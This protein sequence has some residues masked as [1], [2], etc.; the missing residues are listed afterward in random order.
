MSCRLAT[1]LNAANTVIAAYT[2]DNNGNLKTQTQK[3]DAVTT[4]DAITSFDYDPLNRLTKIT[5]ALAGITQYGYDGVDHLVSVTDPKTLITRYGVDGLDNQKQ[6]VS[7]DTGTTNSTYDAAGN[8]KTRTDARA[9][10]STYSYDALNRLT[11]VT[12][13]DTTPAIAYF[14]DDIASGNAGK[15]RL[16]KL[17][18]ATGLT[19][20]TYD[21]QGRLLQKKQTT[22]AGV[23]LKVHTTS[24][25][26]N[27]GN[28]RL[29]SLTYPSAKVVGYTYDAQGRIASITVNGITLVS[30]I[31]YQPFC[32]ATSWLWSGGPLQTRPYDL[33]GRQT[34]YPYTGAGTVSLTYDLGNRIKNLSGTVTK[35]YGYDGP[36]PPGK[37]D[38]L[39]SS[40]NEL[41]GYDGPRPVASLGLPRADSNRSSHTVATT[42]YAYTYPT[43]SNRLTSFTGPAARS[44][45][46]DAAGNILTTGSGFTFSYDARGRMTNITTACVNQYGIKP[47]AATSGINA[48]GPR[49]TKAGTGRHVTIRL[50]RRRG[51]A[52]GHKLLGEYNNAGTLIPEQVY[53][54]DTPI[55]AIKSNGAFVVQ[56]DHLN[57]PRAILRASNGARPPRIQAARGMRRFQKTNHRRYCDSLSYHHAHEFN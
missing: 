3:Y 40:S 26:Y 52:S 53:L 36:R 33:D 42:S 51:L 46:Y 15:G 16:T 38:R 17:T 14:Y 50:R 48:L 39:T 4:N 57:T 7:P 2:Y 35:A 32:P 5:D 10:I 21:I 20:Y 34:S 28:G 30:S 44:Y 12:F 6:L 54:Q 47:R 45:T 41:Y 29:D 8:L 31:S 23:N 1:E 49:L 24:Y 19:E 43:T 56:A 55:A 11:G 25:S 18:D 37:L 9:K 27:A 22:G 13:S